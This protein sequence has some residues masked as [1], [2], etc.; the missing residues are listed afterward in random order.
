MADS[1]ADLLRRTQG[2]HA[3]L[4]RLLATLGDEELT[5]P[6]VTGDWS[7]KDHLAHLTWWQRRVVLVLGGQ[8]DP[9][10]ALSLADQS[11]DAI[12]AALYAG[13][14]YRTL[15]DVRADCDASHRQ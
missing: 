1:R 9:V 15:A 14:R 7:L 2:E 8:P 3:R 11:E 10:G 13:N 5:R 6:G 4:E 12:N